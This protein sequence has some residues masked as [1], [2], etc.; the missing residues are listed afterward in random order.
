MSRKQHK[1]EAV[2]VHESQSQPNLALTVYVHVSVIL[3]E[4]SIGAGDI[5]IG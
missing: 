1:A 2:T 3:H 4:H 5:D